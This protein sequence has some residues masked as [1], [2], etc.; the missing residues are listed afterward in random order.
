M[1]EKYKSLYQSLKLP[2]GLVL[3][4]RFV[5][6]PMSIEG[7][8]ENGAPTDED[9]KFWER[10]ADTAS[11][12]ITGET[13]VS[14][15]GMTSEH[16]L[17]LFDSNL[18]QFKK[19]TKAMKSKGNKAIV[20]MF[21]GGF[22]AGTSYDKLGAAYG[23][24]DL[25]ASVLG[26]PLTGLTEEQIEEVIKEFGH[27]T[28]LAIEAGFDGIELSANMYLLY[29]FFSRYYNR[30]DDKWG[31]ESLKTRCAFDLAII[32]EMRKIIND[33]APDD[34]I[35]GVRFRPEDY[36]L[37][38]G[39]SWANGGDINHTL[40]DTVYLIKQVLKRHVDYI[41]S[42]GW[43]GAGAYKKRARIQSHALVS[44]VLRKAINGRA[45][46][47]VN[48][49]IVNADDMKDALNYGDMFSY[50]T[51][52][53]VE[54]DVKNKIAKNEKLDYKIEADAALPK[55]LAYRADSFAKAN[56]VIAKENPQLMSN[57]KSDATSGASQK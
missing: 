46:L 17:G 44:D 3:P 49:G 45:P 33:E 38:R 52:A 57:T 42:M 18:P 31:K 39:M 25:D 22:K 11:L 10:R 43:G 34:F 9:I 2:N 8:D 37:K 29:S 32:D 41:H 5:V 1:Q 36:A 51:L 56:P 23:P 20:Q 26:Y 14:L 7:A 40:E 55:R 16:Q 28:E 13:S 53:I 48:G 6:A 27:A 35:L 54:P 4:N 50:A 21:H 30:R 47:I 24:S 15:Y 12:L 19:M